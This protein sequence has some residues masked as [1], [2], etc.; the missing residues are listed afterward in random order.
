MYVEHLAPLDVRQS[1]PILFVHGAGMTGTNFLNTP[2]GRPGWADY[3]LS[4][5][6][7]VYLVDQPSRGRSAWQQ[8][9]DGPQSTFNTT[10]IE[11][12]FTAPERYHL[13]PQADLHTQWPGE[14]ISGDPIFDAFYESTMPTLTSRAESAQKFQNA[15]GLLLDRVGPVILLTHSQSGSLGWLLG[16]ARPSLVKA[17]V[18]LEPAGPPFSDA[19]FPPF[20]E[21]RP[22]GIAEIPLQ[23]SPPIAAA[24]ELG[25]EVLNAIPNVT[26]FE[27]ISPA[28]KLTNLASIPVLLVTSESGYH[29]LYDNCTVNF[30]QQ[31]GVSV[32]H[33]ALGD[34]GIHGN[35]HMMFMEKNSDQIVDEVVHKWVKE[36]AERP[37]SAGRTSEA[38]VIVFQL[39]RT[40]SYNV[41]KSATSAFTARSPLDG[42]Q[43]L[44]TSAIHG[45]ALRGARVRR[46]S[47]L[48]DVVTWDQYSFKING[49]RLALWGGEMHPYRLPVPGLWLD[50]LQKI[51][52]AGFNTVSIYIFWGIM[53][54]KRGE[55]SFEGFRDLQ[56]FFDAAKEAG[57]YVITRPGP[58][59]NAET[60]GGGFPGW[61]TYTPGLWRTSNVTYVEAYQNYIRAVG[62]KVAE[63]EITKGGPVILFQSENEY[64]GWQE[65]YTEDFDYEKR[66]LEDIRASGVTVPITTND[67]YPGGHYTS[68]DVYGYDSY[69][70][71]F[72]CANPY[73]WAP[74]A[75][76][77]WLWDARMAINPEDPNAMFENQGGAI[78]GWG[79][80]GGDNCAILT[81]PDFERVFY[82][83]QFAMSTTVWNIYMFYGG[84]NWG[85]I[86]FPGSYT[87]YD[88]G[89]AIAENRF[90]REK[91]YEVKLQANFGRVSPAFLTSRPMNIGASQGAFTGNQ[92]LKTT[93]VLDV[94]GKQTG[95]YVVR[96]TDASTHDTQTYKL[97]VPTSLGNLTIPAIGGSLAL[98]GR[99]SKIH[100]VDYTAG[101][102]RVVYSSA[103]IFTW[104][105]IDGMDVIV[106]Y[107]NAG[108]LHETAIAYSG[109][110]TT[111]TAS[112]VDGKG[113]IQQKS[114]SASSL[115]IQY[116]T[117]G[118]TVVR[119]G[120]SVILYLLDRENAYQF[121]VPPSPGQFAHSAA[122][123][124]PVIIKGG[125]LL[126]SVTTSNGQL[127]IV[128]DLN[129]TASLEILGPRALTK[130]VTFNGKELALKGTDHG[131]L[132]GQVF[133]ALPDV[134]IPDL[135]TLNWKSA[136]SLP[137]IS[138]EY[139]DSIW[140]VANHTETVNPTVPRT[141]V[142]LYASDY[143]YHT[144]N[145]LW[146]AH[147]NATGLET[148]FTVN[149][150]GGTA[151]G[152][153]V[154]LDQTFIGSFAG[155]WAQANHEGSF[156]FPKQLES[157]S[158][159][160]L[161]ILQDHMGL[162]E[163]W[164]GAGEDFKTPRGIMSYAFMGS[165]D[166]SVDVWKIAG[167]LG[168]EDYIDKS[169]GP[170]NEGGLFAERQGWHLP[171]FNDDAW[172]SGKPTEGISRA[173]VAFYRTT[174]NL[175]I[176]EGLDYALSFVT[177]N[178]TTNPHFR[179]KLYV[180]GYQYGKYGPQKSFPV[181]QGILNYR[182]QNT[183]AVSLW[184][185]DE[186]GAKLD[187]LEM[188]LD[189][190]AQ[191]GYEPVVNAPMQAWAP[192]S[193][194]F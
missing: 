6:Y 32:R 38:V 129:T 101:S 56:P 194:S 113:P 10:Y 144:G 175:G 158:S 171:G 108:E 128:G 69:P 132:V 159:H 51:K 43:V 130:S 173:G 1:L 123:H 100:V 35:G 25:R 80:A 125:Y 72:D 79:G 121:W 133:A 70:N 90:L 46:Q 44:F 37:L 145:I 33:I 131:S 179:T 187:S 41:Q 154:W 54:A 58:Y 82:K 14:G 150:S 67:A 185:M 176:P 120:E 91:Y 26:C 5:G 18:A 180:N 162:N 23:F 77:E 156:D 177:S 165:N 103:E 134:S 55:V 87:S 48:Q 47:P 107:G 30:L 39:T 27:Q 73:T 34:I 149:V 66:L 83:N 161:T 167:N 126:R 106:L 20:A 42:S 117:S 109:S 49:T 114:L 7:E 116:T 84:T 112:V 31:A 127:A 45:T 170:L 141:P 104:A 15:G 13:W 142:V 78:D 65:P 17:I 94:V 59:I 189:A 92:A 62:E 172:K 64:T 148:G 68:V 97:T 138:Q 146:R 57:L 192:R 174:F 61:G 111:L 140:T 52:A 143:G 110:N 164:A 190:K 75:V 188:K 136:D 183:L 139:S 169:R 11:S 40:Q 147:F 152:Y 153:S 182:G 16:D 3:F 2:D 95:F 74:D 155:D 86:A 135:D 191:T 19:V 28:R 96:Q 157:G 85:G 105:T 71:G 88:Y 36:I 178:S 98:N 4:K 163:N 63:N 93:Q 118:Q 137:E 99:D 168:G 151:F 166:T 119:V 8:N 9:I 193:G 124:E 53:E 122:P 184:A 81:G 22:Y 60:T 89:A 186:S 160:V 24:G 50:I 102:T 181:P 29:A 115:A 12:H 21:T 76:P